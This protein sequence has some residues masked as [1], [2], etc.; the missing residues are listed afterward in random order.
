MGPVEYIINGQPALKDFGSEPKNTNG[1]SVLLRVDYDHARILLTGDLNKKSQQHLLDVLGINKTEL[2]ADVL[3]ACHHGSDDCSYNFI[4]AIK[5]SASIISSGDDEAHGHPRP[6]IVAA[7]GMCGNVLIQNDEVVTPLVFSTEISRSFRIGDPDM[8]KFENYTY[9]DE[10]ID[11]VLVDEEKTEISYKRAV[12]PLKP[13][14]L[15]KMM[16]R[17]KIVDGIVYGLVNVRTDGNKILCATLNEGDSTW[18]IKKFN[19]RF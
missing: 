11:I 15:K 5:P 3:K 7:L 17:L 19:A 2:E 4:S 6:N 13:K 12:P 16:N 8:V 14:H 1:N 9:G 18:D 10:E